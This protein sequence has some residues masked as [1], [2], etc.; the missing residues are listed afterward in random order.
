MK[1]V[2]LGNMVVLKQKEVEK[3]TAS[4]IILASTSQEKPKQAVVVAVGPGE[5]V[6]GKQME[7]RVAPGDIVIY[8]KYS[9]TDNVK[10]DDEEYIIVNQTD[11]VAKITE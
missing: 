8:H 4:G 3:T 2:P 10:L 7:M 5:I 11:I 6:D 1:L 9:G